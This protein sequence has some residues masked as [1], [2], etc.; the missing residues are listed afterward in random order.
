MIFCTFHHCFSICISTLSQNVFVTGGNTLYRGFK[1][2]LENE[3]RAMRPF[4]SKF[5]VFLAGNEANYS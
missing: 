3:L 4:K 5:R 2:R 1:T